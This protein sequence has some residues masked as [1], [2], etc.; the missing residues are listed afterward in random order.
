MPAPVSLDPFSWESLNQCADEQ[1]LDRTLLSQLRALG[2]QNPGMAQTFFRAVGKALNSVLRIGSY[3]KFVECPWNELVELYSEQVVRSQ[4]F[5]ASPEAGKSSDVIPFSGKA[6]TTVLR[7]HSQQPC[8]TVTVRRRV[9]VVR[10]LCALDEPILVL[11][12]DD[13]LSLALAEAGYKDVTTLDI[14]PSLIRKLSDEAKRRGVTIKARTQDLLAPLP[15]DLVRPYRVAVFDP[16]CTVEGVRFFTEAAVR[17]SG[18][19]QETV[20]FLNTHLM[21]LLRPGLGE[22]KGFMSAQGFEVSAFYPAFNV[23]PVS[24]GAQRLLRILLTVLNG[25]FFRSPALR[26]KDAVVKWFVSD[27]ML[28]RHKTRVAP[29][30]PPETDIP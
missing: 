13:F 20:F 26:S 2:A 30:H 4:R 22:L 7:K 16:M 12:D 17:L 10:G 27:A 11:G 9:E 21:S 1:A 18:G 25:L 8:T 24:S 5:N 19:N 3:G 29:N 28:L 23:Y 14:D 15:T 6:F